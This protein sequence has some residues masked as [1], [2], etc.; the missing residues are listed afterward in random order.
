[1]KIGKPYGKFSLEK[2]RRTAM[3]T[4]IDASAT[5]R[6]KEC[7]DKRGWE[8]DVLINN[9]GFPTK[10]LLEN[11]DY[12]RQH[13]ELNVNVIAVTELTY[14]FIGKMAEKGKGTVINIASAAAFN[15]CPY[16]SVYAATKAYVLSFSQAIQYEYVMKGVQVLAVCPQATETH[17]FDDFNK[18]S[19]KMR[20]PEDVVRTTLR[21]LEKRKTV[22]MDGFACHMQSIMPRIFSRK[23]RVK[24]TGA[25]CKRIWG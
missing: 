17:F 19:G 24:I 15:P 20:M 12:D 2:E 1:M 4:L 11:S 7:V 21:A 9:A 23:T 25:V 18:M 10:G 8:V 5:E 16:N 6:V 3:E 14:Q 13:R 22:A